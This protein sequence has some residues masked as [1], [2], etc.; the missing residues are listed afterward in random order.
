[1]IKLSVAVRGC[2]NFILSVVQV[3]AGA[4]GKR[5]VLE[6]IESMREF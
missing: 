6:G 2:L 3:D 1:M 4:I 5:L